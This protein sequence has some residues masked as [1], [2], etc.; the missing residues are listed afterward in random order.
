M[1]AAAC[2][3]ALTELSEVNCAWE[4]LRQF[5]TS[6]A[7][8]ETAININTTTEAVSLGMKSLPGSSMRLRRREVEIEEVI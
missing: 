1:G 6:Q 2:R 8:V 7:E 5:C 3:P 4:E